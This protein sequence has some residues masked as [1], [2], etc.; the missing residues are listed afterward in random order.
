[1]PNNTE[2]TLHPDLHAL[3]SAALPHA[4]ET[5]RQRGDP[6]PFGVL[7]NAD[8][9]MNALTPREDQM[10]AVQVIMLRT[11]VRSMHASGARGVA[12]CYHGRVT[13]VGGAETD[14]ILV[15]AE[16]AT[17][18]AAKAIFPYHRDGS[19]GYVFQPGE[20]VS[21]KP[22]LFRSGE[23]TSDHP[24]IISEPR[25][26]I[27][28][29]EWERFGTLARQDESVLGPLFGSVVVS[30][31]APPVCDVLLLYCTIQPG[32][33]I[34]GSV[35]DFWEIIRDSEA[36]IV[37]IATEHVIERYIEAER[38]AQIAIN[39]VLTL[40]RRDDAFARYFADLFGLMFRNISMPMAWSRLAPQFAGAAHD[41]LPETVFS[42]G[43]GQI[44]FATSQAAAT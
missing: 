10:S 2:A 20:V 5:I 9:S 7:M 30:D 29:L 39:L 42:P 21:C 26:G 28:M 1:M 33:F 14:A 3:L 34:A 22:G 16:H 37:I 6:T 36:S 40:G 32:G 8:G 17:G 41:H 19:L 24:V 15:Q 35:L 27:L 18:E 38:D 12:I 25:L 13:G 31:G 23:D 11:G 4:Q 44:A 43:G